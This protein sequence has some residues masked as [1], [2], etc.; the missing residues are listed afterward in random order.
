MALPEDEKL[1]I[2]AA[3]RVGATLRETL[4]GGVIESLE[5]TVEQALMVEL[6]V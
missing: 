2:E 6:D 3:L 5:E 4:E 1:G